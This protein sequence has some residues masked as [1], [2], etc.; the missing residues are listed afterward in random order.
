MP[1]AIEVSDSLSNAPEQIVQAAIVLGKGAVRPAVF[2][3]IYHHKA[4]V[5]SVTA[6][7]AKTA[8]DRIRVLQ[9]GQHLVRNGIVRRTQKAGETAYEMIP[10]FHTHKAK[11]VSLAAAPKRL[12]GIPTKR[13]NH[14]SVKVIVRG[15]RRPKAVELTIDDIESFS[16]VRSIDP[17]GYIP[18][19][20]SE[21]TFKKGVQAILGDP[22]DWRDWGGEL[23]DLVTTNVRLKGKRV[24]TVF[25]FKGPGMRGPLISKKMGKNGDQISRMFLDDAKMFVVQYGE[26]IKPSLVRDLKTFAI[27][28]SH[29]IDE[30]IY[31]LAIDGV[32][33]NR[34]YLAYRNRFG[35]K[36]TPRKSK[37]R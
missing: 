31:F 6:I 17:N 25:A 32:D 24:R 9:E 29:A 7:V 37:R 12:A 27:S 18:R 28:K 10:F 3:A 13:N 26:E 11:I 19:T 1:N 22:G 34:L 8:I 33:S 5:K 35:S 23:S 21:Y 20:V 14:A 36:S 16:A 2:K 4:K 15:M 30:T